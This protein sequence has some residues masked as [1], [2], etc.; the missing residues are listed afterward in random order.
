[1]T[2]TEGSDMDDSPYEPMDDEL[3][4]IEERIHLLDDEEARSDIQELINELK[5]E[6]EG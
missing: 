6:T 5:A 4:A 2:V 3:E 1:M